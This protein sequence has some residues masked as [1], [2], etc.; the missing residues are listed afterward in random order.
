MANCFN[1]AFLSSHK[2]NTEN[3][4]CSVALLSLNLVDVTS[5][6]HRLMQ[7]HPR[8]SVPKAVRQIWDGKHGMGTD[9]R[10]TITM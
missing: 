2:K 1:L 9:I 8:L 6:L 3:G 5:W 4:K 7:Y 10:W